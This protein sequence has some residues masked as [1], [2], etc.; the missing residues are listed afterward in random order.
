[1]ARA[2]VWGLG[3]SAARTSRKTRTMFGERGLPS[4]LLVCL[5]VVPLLCVFLIYSILLQ[6]AGFGW[7]GYFF[8]CRPQDWYDVCMTD[9][10]ANPLS[11]VL[12]KN[13]DEEETDRLISNSIFKNVGSRFLFRL[14]ISY[15]CW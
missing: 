8:P 4:C 5:F 14:G 6:W 7:D 1:M 15:W 2:V 12:P 3:E 11:Y 13:N 10:V 9:C